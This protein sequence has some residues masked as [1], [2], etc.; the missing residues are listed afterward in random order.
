LGGFMAKKIEDNKT[1]EEETSFVQKLGP[2][3][4]ILGLVIA[5]GAAA[6]KQ[7]FWLLGALGF[8]VGLLNINYTEEYKFLISSLTF[9]VSANVLSVTLGQMASFVPLI[10]K[11]SVLIGALLA[12]ISVFVAPA[13]GV[14]ALKSLYKISK[15]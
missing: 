1:A 3:A 6:T 15:D 9:L 5:V 7:I 14:V 4:F 13:A 12:N 8:I 10:D 11:Y 2:W